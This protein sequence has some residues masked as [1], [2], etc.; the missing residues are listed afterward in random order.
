MITDWINT[1][2]YA[3]AAAVIPSLYSTSEVKYS[4]SVIGNTMFLNFS[5]R[6]RTGSGITGGSNGSGVYIFLTPA[7]Y[8][9]DIGA[10]DIGNNLTTY[11]NNECT[12]S[13]VGSGSIQVENSSAIPVNVH[14]YNFGTNNGLVL[15]NPNNSGIVTGTSTAGSANY[16]FGFGSSTWNW[17]ATLPII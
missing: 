14:Y 7:A 1:V 2:A 12:S 16:A 11:S 4:Y 17:T 8:T 3:G 5:L 13:S 9:I 15:V 10:I 6:W